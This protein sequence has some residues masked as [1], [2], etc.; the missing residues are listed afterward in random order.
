LVS[1]NIT[2]RMKEFS[3]RKVFGA[4]VS[5]IFKLMNKDYIWILSIAFLIG[6]PGGFLLVNSLIQNIYPDPTPA[7]AT[8]FIIGMCI[9]AVTVA[10]TV[11]SQISRIT[12]NNPAVT[13]R[14]E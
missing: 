2:R 10:I 14:S 11:T 1:Y 13:L 8:P 12:K 7:S 3:V 4:N 6:A 5:H 9:M